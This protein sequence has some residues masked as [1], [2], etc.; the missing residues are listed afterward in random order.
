[1]LERPVQHIAL[2]VAKE[3]EAS[4]PSGSGEYVSIV[5]PRSKQIKKL[6]KLDTL[7]DQLRA[8]V[9]KKQ[10][11]KEKRNAPNKGFG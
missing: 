6:N 3:T 8:T 7:R 5:D 1:M 10:E 11:E 9:K 4:D 2:E